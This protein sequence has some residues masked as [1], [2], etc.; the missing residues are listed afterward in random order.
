MLRDTAVLTDAVHLDA[1]GRLQRCRRGMEQH[2]RRHR[3]QRWNL[4]FQSAAQNENQYVDAT[5]STRTIVLTLRFAVHGRQRVKTVN[6][7]VVMNVGKI[8]RIKTGSL[9]HSFEVCAG[10]DKDERVYTVVGDLMGRSFSYY[11]EKEELCAVMARTK[12]ALI[13]NAVLGSGSENTI[14]IAPGV[15][16]S[17]ILA[18]T[19]GVLQCGASV[20][21]DAAKNFLVSPAKNVAV[22]SA[23]DQVT[24]DGD[25][26]LASAVEGGVEGLEGVAEAG[27]AAVAGIGDFVMQMFVG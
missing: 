3:A 26:G 7:E 6:D 25:E 15:D 21:T 4:Q 16:C 8:S 19:F 11:N 27:G 13:K 5:F 12:K 22:D 17:A 20:I 1:G 2:L 23:M 24:G 9:R 10:D 18:A 14:D